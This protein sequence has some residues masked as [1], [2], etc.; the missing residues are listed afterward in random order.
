M[1]LDRKFQMAPTC[2]LVTLGSLQTDQQYY[3]VHAERVNTSYVYSVLLAKMDSP[4]N[5]VKLFL[6]K[7]HGDV[8]EGNTDDINSQRVIQYL[9]YKRHVQSPTRIS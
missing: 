6:S 4:T 1:E 2:R 7:R 3:I 5:K 9:I 8:S